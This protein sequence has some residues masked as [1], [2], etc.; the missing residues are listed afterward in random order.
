MDEK[1]RK[2]NFTNAFSDIAKVD[3]AKAIGHL[4]F[5]GADV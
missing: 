2:Y 4:R 3:I 1:S 5:V